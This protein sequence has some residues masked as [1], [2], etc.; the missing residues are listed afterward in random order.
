M[1]DVRLE[2]EAPF[3]A[4]IDRQQVPDE[5]DPEIGI[6]VH[7]RVVVAADAARHPEN[8]RVAFAGDN[9]HLAVE[10]PPELEALDL[11]AAIA[12]SERRDADESAVGVCLHLIHPIAPGRRTDAAVVGGRNRQTS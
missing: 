6:E 3:P 10:F 7:A 1:R 12:A 9:A 5:V 4:G 2:I 8:L 11:P